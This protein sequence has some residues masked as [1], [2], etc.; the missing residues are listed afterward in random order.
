L[1]LTLIIAL[2]QIEIKKMGRGAHDFEGKVLCASPFSS[3]KNTECIAILLYKS[4]KVMVYN[5]KNFTYEFHV[6]SFEK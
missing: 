4:I 3:S 2:G 5:E 1:G 6:N